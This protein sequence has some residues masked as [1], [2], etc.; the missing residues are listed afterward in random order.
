V[1]FIIR[2]ADSLREKRIIV[3]ANNL[4]IASDALSLGAVLVTNNTREFKRIEKV[5]FSK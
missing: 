2:I 5:C 4:L 3:G 1:L